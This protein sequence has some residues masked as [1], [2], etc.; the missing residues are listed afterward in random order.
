MSCECEKI[1]MLVCAG[2]DSILQSLVN[3][4]VE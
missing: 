4:M 2:L 3:G 1:T